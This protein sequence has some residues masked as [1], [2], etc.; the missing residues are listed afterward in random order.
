MPTNRYSQFFAAYN[1]SKKKGNNN[2]K[3]ET[4][5]SFTDGRTDS[6]KDLSEWE[7]QELNRQL[8][9]IAPANNT[10]EDKMRKAIIAIFK[11]MNRPT[12]DAIGWAEKQ[13]V[14]GEKKAFNDYTTQELYVLI[15]VAEKVLYDW[16]T[17]IRKTI[18]KKI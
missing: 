11:K 7:L 8:S 15:H 2:T 18:L 16:Q 12:A 3:E 14:R 1:A 17:A 10:K 13:G 9:G 4:V 5:Y 6:L